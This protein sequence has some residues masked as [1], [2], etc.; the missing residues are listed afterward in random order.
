MHSK[1]WKWWVCGVL[2]LATFLNY[3]DRQALAMSLPEMKR[4]L[5]LAEE[6][7][8]LV[9]GVFGYRLRR[10]RRSSLAFWPIGSGPRRLYPVVLIGWSLAGIA[11]GFAGHAEVTG[12]LEMPGDEPGAGTFRWLLVWRTIL[13]L[14]EAGHWP[15]AYHR[16]AN[17]HCEG[18][19]ARQWHPPERRIGGVDPD[20][21]VRPDRRAF[22]R[23]LADRRSGRSASSGLLWVPHLA[24]A[25]A[26]RQSR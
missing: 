15:C 21:D 11:T 23:R 22:W 9:E 13:G 25:R 6:R 4:T 19:A 2:L 7:I 20:P 5:H 16:S 8:G 17:P 12:W 24:G 18:P 3:M 14:F 26:A 10:R 1:S